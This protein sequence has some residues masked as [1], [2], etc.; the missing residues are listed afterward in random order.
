MYIYKKHNL[1]M[2]IFI[3][4]IYRPHIPSPDSLLL[5]TEI[6]SGTHHFMVTIDDLAYHLMLSACHNVPML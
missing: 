4:K 2:Y 6:L 5:T 1:S 3:L